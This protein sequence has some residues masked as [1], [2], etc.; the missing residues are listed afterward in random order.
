MY[1]NQHPRHRAW[2][3]NISPGRSQRFQ[4]GIDHLGRRN[5]P[6]LLGAGLVTTHQGRSDR[7]G[8][9]W[10]PRTDVGESGAK[11][12]NVTRL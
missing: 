3:W 1:N 6:A 9:H 12:S 10:D 11:V 5:I 8:T 4:C 7:L 2:L